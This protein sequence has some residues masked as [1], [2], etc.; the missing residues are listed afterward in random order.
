MFV[1]DLFKHTSPLIAIFSFIA[2]IMAIH[3]NGLEME[4]SDGQKV[5]LELTRI[6]NL[7]AAAFA[8]QIGLYLLLTPLE[9]V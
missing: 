9:I 8:V 7:I 1:F 2:L 6:R 4:F 5:I 3:I